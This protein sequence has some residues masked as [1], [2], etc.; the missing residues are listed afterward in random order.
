M[1]E[2]APVDMAPPSADRVAT[3]HR[4]RFVLPLCRGQLVADAGTVDAEGQAL[5][6]AVA[7]G[8]LTADQPGAAAV[9]LS[10]MALRGVQLAG[11]LA[12]LRR[13]LRPGGVLVVTVSDDEQAARA[14]L[15][16]S[17]HHVAVFRQRPLAGTLV[18]GERFAGGRIVALADQ[19]DPGARWTTL[20]VASDSELPPIASL[21]FE[22]DPVGDMAAR[23]AKPPVP[24]LPAGEP[25]LTDIPPASPDLLDLR[26]RAVS[27]VERLVELDERSFDQQA[28]AGKLRGQLAQFQ[29][30]TGNVRT[31]VFDIPRTA[32][33]WPVA[34]HP[35]RD[36]ADLTYYEHRPDDDAIDAGR[37][38]EAFLRQFAL[39]TDQA[40]PSGCAAA[41]NLAPRL[42]ELVPEGAEP[43]PDVSI[44]I[45]VYGQIAYTL[46]CLDSLLAHASR[47]TAE[48]IVIDDLSPDETGAVLPTIS[49]IRFTATARTSVSCAA[50]TP[51]QRWRAAACWCC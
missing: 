11:T 9:V 32:Y 42:L 51:V 45:P 43:P 29:A 19:P 36:R 34:D 48:I 17:W 35:G 21:L 18:T 46:N 37:A 40:D 7:A 22:A 39:L 27:L 23:P 31:G 10:L 14:A 50:A 24:S 38:G 25:D 15:A 20:L 49:G 28:E 1:T 2:A 13:R 3:L 26:R 47:S 5:I 16:A 12:T 44:I 6:A 8:L 4:Y 30:E 41:L 33:A